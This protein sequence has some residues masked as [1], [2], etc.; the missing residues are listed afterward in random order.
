MRRWC[1]PNVQWSQL[2]LC[3]IVLFLLGS[4]HIYRGPNGGL[5]TLDDPVV[6]ED[7]S[8]LPDYRMYQRLKF[9]KT[10]RRL[11]QAIIIGVRK[12]GT[13]ALLEMLFMHKSVQKANGE[14]HFFDRDDNYNQGLEWYRKRMPYSYP[15]QITI[16]KSPS[17]FVTSEVPERI[18]AMNSSVKLLLILREPVIRAIS[19][20]TQLHSNPMANKSS[21]SFEQLVIRSDGTVNINYRPISVSTY[22]NHIYRWLD[23]FPR[24]QLFVVNG[25]RLITNPVS[26]LRRIESFLGLDH[27]IGAE[28]FYFNR[29]KGF[30]CLRYQSG[31]KCLKETK[32]RKHPDVH[33]LVISKLREHFSQHNQKLYDVLGQDFG[34]PEK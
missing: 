34:W 13:R 18:K 22:H 2:V 26:E 24:E 9:Q 4:L 33:P 14:V 11:P 10:T 23:V 17:Y 31:D 29:T 1:I 27:R 15:N 20:Y 7:T 30:Y 28:H 19:D 12:G 6:G 25:D 16:E 3:A 5:S 21:K 32:G 8:T